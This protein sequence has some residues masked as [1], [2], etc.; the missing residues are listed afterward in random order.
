ME[1]VSNGAV[2]GAA[3]GATHGS[4]HVG[5]LTQPSSALDL[6]VQKPTI[7]PCAV[8]NTKAGNVLE[9]LK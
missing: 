4:S 3:N 5:V 7:P 6:Q 1:H 9:R 8:G 2:A